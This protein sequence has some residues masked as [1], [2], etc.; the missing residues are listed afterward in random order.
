M[1]IDGNEGR[2]AR[3][4]RA[5]VLSTDNPRHPAPA[6]PETHQ[7]KRDRRRDFVQPL[8]ASGQ[9][10]ARARLL[11]VNSVA[12]ADIFSFL[13]HGGYCREALRGAQR[14]SYNAGMQTI[15]IPP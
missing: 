9:P 1:P 6:H 11:A 13:V 10:T 12:K 2:R 3:D 14:L 5:D 8:T 15:A 4:R 7:P